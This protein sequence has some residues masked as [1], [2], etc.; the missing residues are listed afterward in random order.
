MKITKTCWSRS[1]NYQNNSQIIR[2]PKTDLYSLPQINKLYN[3]AQRYI[4]VSHIFLFTY[5]HVLS[6]FFTVKNKIKFDAFWS[7]Y[8]EHAR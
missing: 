4:D 6:Q 3:S 2:P 1:E 8:S 7:K 5:Y